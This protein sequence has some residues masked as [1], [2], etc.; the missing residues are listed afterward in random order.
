M[1]ARGRA[2]GEARARAPPRVRKT[3]PSPPCKGSRASIP[4]PFQAESDTSLKTHQNRPPH[5]FVSPLSGLSV[6][7]SRYPGRRNR[8]LRSRFLCPGLTCGCPFR[9]A[10]AGAQDSSRVARESGARNLS[11]GRRESCSRMCTRPVGPRHVSPRQ[12]EWR[13]TSQNAAPGVRKT[14]PAPPCH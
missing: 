3:K 6:C 5:P 11:S 2:N 9:A 7:V 14:K 13:G 4:V 10:S 8:S 12:S 1:S